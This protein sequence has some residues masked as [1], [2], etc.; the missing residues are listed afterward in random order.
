MIFSGTDAAD[1]HDIFLAEG[2]T[3]GTSQSGA[4]ALVV[5][6]PGHSPVPVGVAE[7]SL[8]TEAVSRPDDLLFASAGLFLG[9]A[10]VE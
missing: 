3:V 1:F 9:T 8:Q 7:G 6:S 10:K 5:N 4:G 2:H